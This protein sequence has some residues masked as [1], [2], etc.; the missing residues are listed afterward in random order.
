LANCAWRALKLYFDTYFEGRDLIP[1]A[2]RVDDR[3]TRPQAGSGAV[4][5]GH[6]MIRCPI[7]LKRLSWE[8]EAGEIVYRSRHSRRTGP[9]DGH[10]RWDVLE[11]LARVVDHIPE[12]SQQMVRYWGFY[13]N[14]ARGKRRKAAADEDTPREPSRQD[15]EIT[16]RTRLSWALLVRR[17]LRGRPVA[18]PLLRCRDED[19]R[20]IRL[21]LW[22]PGPT[23]GSLGHV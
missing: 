8:W 11:F 9:D 1:G 23:P 13:A 4:R 21:I 17:V 19:P 16:R 12:P 14:A 3:G 2:V 15:D 7:V 6:Y 22:L 18:L 10:A 5:L 20:R